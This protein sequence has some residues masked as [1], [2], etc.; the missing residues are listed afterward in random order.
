MEVDWERLR[1][2]K[3]LWRA[4]GGSLRNEDG[5]RGC[6]AHGCWAAWLGLGEAEVRRFSFYVRRE[7]GKE[8]D[9]RAREFGRC[10]G[11]VFFGGN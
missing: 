3:S 9:K 1:K 5:Q 7:F 10:R 11:K 6:V 2:S 8:R 4:P